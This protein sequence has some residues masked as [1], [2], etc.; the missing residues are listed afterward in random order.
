MEPRR[1]SAFTLIELLVVL[2]IIALV[3]AATLPTVLPA[4]QHRQISE[5]ARLVQATIEGQRDAAIRFNAARGV[6]LL[7]DPAFPGSTIDPTV[8][9][10]FSRLVPLEPAPDYSEGLVSVWSDAHP[11]NIPYPNAGGSPYPAEVLRIEGANYGPDGLP[12]ARTNW[13]WNVR[14]GDRIRIGTAGHLYTVVGPL[15]LF[16]ADNPELFV[17]IGPPGSPSP[18]ARSFK[19]IDGNATETVEFLYLVNGVDDDGDGYTDEGWDGVDNDR[20]DATDEIAPPSEWEPEKWL[21][22][23]AQ[24]VLAR[25]YVIKRRPVPTQG[26]R[27]VSLP[28]DVVI[29]ASTWQTT[30]ER[31]RLP[32]DPN[33]L[34][35]DLM[36]SPS[37]QVI[38]TT[39]YSSPASAGVSPFLHLWISERGDVHPPASTGA[40]RLPMPSGVI[41][42]ASA[43]LSGERRLVTIQGRSG[44]VTTTEVEAFNAADPNVPFFAGQAGL[45]EA[46]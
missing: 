13:Y 38:P 1:R 6:R 32:V 24:G 15:K 42:G 43:V 4:L 36:I 25:P 29:D 8:P 18:I 17:N 44:N 19:V 11:G 20:D 45:R 34:S 2:T 37:G 41:P 33:T 10:A 14:V 35:V 21:G 22:S 5:S 39:V 12:V 9:L 26:A 28:S 46:R 30:R 7:P 16:G 3:S 31:S 40:V 23:E 27:V